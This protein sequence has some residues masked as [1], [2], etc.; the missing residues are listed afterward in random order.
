MFVI[1]AKGYLVG[2]SFWEAD[3]I[4]TPVVGLYVDNAIVAHAACELPPQSTALD[5][6]H[7]RYWFRLN[8]TI[9]QM[10]RIELGDPAV[11]LLR[12]ED[13]T[14]IRFQR[15]RGALIAQPIHRVEDFLTNAEHPTAQLDGFPKYL[16]APLAHQLDVLFIDILGRRPDPGAKAEYLPRLRQ[17]ETILGIRNILM[18]SK[19]FHE[20]RLTI[21]DRI[22]SLITSSLWTLFARN[23][24]LGERRPS[25]NQMTIADYAALSDA[26]F[27]IAA[28]RDCHGD[29]PTEPTVVDLSGIAATRGRREVIDRL[30][31]DAATGGRYFDLSDA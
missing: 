22:G 23:E 9:E 8:A 11:K 17:G 1:D 12:I 30:R 24:P 18:S 29:D 10:E 31:R 13:A 15:S 25:V 6:P 7:G 4:Y 16:T 19:E 20:R 21:S 28:H 3:P 2:F 27:V 14:P 5:G 26:D